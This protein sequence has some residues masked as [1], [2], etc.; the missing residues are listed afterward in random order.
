MNPL[1]A[2]KLN[3]PDLGASF[4]FL[5]SS[6]GVGPDPY[7]GTSGMAQGANLAASVDGRV[8]AGVLVV[9]LL[10]V[11]GFYVWTRGVQA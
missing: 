7:G 3:R 8:T 2:Q 6:S 9:A 10:V 11:A 4:S 5:A 1:L